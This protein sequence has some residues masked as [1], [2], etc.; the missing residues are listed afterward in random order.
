MNKT[1]L[2]YC[3]ILKTNINVT[4]MDGTIAYITENLDALKGDYICV[5]NVH[6][7]VMAYRDKEYRKIQNSAAMALPDGQPLSIV[8]RR[9]GYAQAQRVPGPD[10]MPAILDLSQE[11][12][13]THYFYGSTEHTLT[14]LREELLKRYPKLQIAGMYAPPFRELTV[15]EDEEAVRRINESGAD[16]VWVA[17]GAP[18]QERWMYAH[19]NRVR[20]LMLGVGAAFDFIAGTV[21]RAPMWMQKLCM[22][23]VFRIMQDPRRMLPRYL[24]TNFA[25][26][27]YV[28]RE[29]RALREKK[30]RESSIGRGADAQRNPV[31]SSDRL[32]IAMIGHKRIPSREGGIEIVVEELAVRMAAQGHRVD[33][34]NRYGH[35]VSGKK[36]DQE[37]G[38]KGRKYY[39][40]VRVYIVP[41]FHASSLNAIVYSFFA[42]I[43]AL[44][45]RY[46]VLHYHA[47][48]PCAMLWLPRL[49]HRKIVVT[50][51]GLDWQRAKW[52]NFA[53]FVIRF[54]EKMAAGY[55][56]EVIVLSENVRQYFADTYHRQVTYIP[57]GITRPRL[58][59]PEL[60][61]EKYGLTK[62]GYFLFLGRIVPEK[63]LHYLIEAFAETET[64]K[65]LVIAGGNSQAVEYMERIHYMAKQDRRVVMTDFVQGQLL[66][67]LYSNAYAFVL[68]SD[69]EGMALS[70]LEAMSYGNCCLVSDICENTEVVE[71]K[72]LVFHKS[73]VADL[74]EKLTY[75]LEHPEI[76][77]ARAA[78]SADFICG[79]YNWDDV[80]DETVR[81]YHRCRENRKPKIQN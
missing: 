8:S 68:P 11:R 48:G 66:E 28:H 42:T 56:D 60:I 24:S 4:D 23:W 18:K 15:E 46:D 34:Y 29:N 47:E 51:H 49:F 27:Y 30:G 63:G 72:A 71:D 64:D 13:Y 77:H 33:V 78:E 59:E 54:G 10:L 79:K 35:H 31:G 37:Y 25:F 32:H 50:V 19:R 21:K 16:F 80:V 6:T 17:L 62:D 40:G 65:K 20:G 76:V 70:L 26:L 7:T 14:R 22:E 69:V 45:G 43:R 1:D 3:T 75:M 58:R 57:N 44:F 74:R 38:W 61:A 53:S 9:R 39:K 81:L 52:G 73:D 67:E 12:G 55:A 2:K 5:S 36:Y 41:T